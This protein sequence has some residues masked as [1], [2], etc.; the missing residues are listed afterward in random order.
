[1]LVDYDLSSNWGNWQYLTGVGN[2]SRGER[3]FNLIK[4][5]FGYDPK[6]NYVKAKVSEL[7]RLTQ[8]SEI[9]QGWTV[10]DARKQ[11]LG[12]KGK[13]RIDNPLLK[14]KFTVGRR[15][16][17]LEETSPHRHCMEQIALRYLESGEALWLMLEEGSATMRGTGGSGSTMRWKGEGGMKIQLLGQH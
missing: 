9:F 8:P 6:G 13:D 1:M 11:V 3:I 17:H 2:D 10:L 5:V 15:R 4:Q 16:P 12:P 14:I 7:K